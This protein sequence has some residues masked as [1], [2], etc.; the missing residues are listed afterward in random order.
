MKLVKFLP[1]ASVF[2]LVA[3]DMPD[4]SSPAANDGESVEIN[5]ET[6][7]QKISYLMGL[8]N[9]NNIRAMDL[10]IDAEAFQHGLT[11]ALAGS[12]PKLT[13]DQI[14]ETIKQF[15]S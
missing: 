13:E 1:L 9:G 12:E 8:D 11:S 6:Q 10:E 3:C 14:A 7:T 5:L 4:N 2:F 15:E